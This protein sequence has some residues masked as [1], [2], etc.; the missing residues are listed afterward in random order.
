MFFEGAR[1]PV[2][3]NGAVLPTGQKIKKGK[4]RG[5]ESLGMLCSGEELLLKEGDY[6]GAGVYGILIL[7]KDEKVGE[8]I[9][10][11]LHLND[12]RH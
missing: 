6:E 9:A 2:A 11:A 4:L 5:V 7:K 10:D 12:A 3:L 1:V 8:D